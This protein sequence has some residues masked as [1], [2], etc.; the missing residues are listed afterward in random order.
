MQ[1]AF[2]RTPSTS[3]ASTSILHRL[4]PRFTDPIVCLSLFILVFFH[5]HLPRLQRWA[6]VQYRTY[7]SESNQITKV[8]LIKL[9]CYFLKLYFIRIIVYYIIIILRKK[10]LTA[11]VV[12][13]FQKFIIYALLA[14]KFNLVTYVAIICFFENYLSSRAVSGFVI[15]HVCSL[16]LP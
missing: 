13:S 6:Q 3:C 2:V 15:K 14:Q 7:E 8:H 9:E 11:M 4:S 16:K 12:Y 5:R 10:K 1:I